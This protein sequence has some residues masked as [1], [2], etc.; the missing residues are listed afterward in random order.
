[1]LVRPIEA[2]DKDSLVRAF[3][4]L[5]PESRYRRFLASMKRLSP[6]LLRHLTEIDHRDHEALVALSPDELELVGV[7][8]FI[9][10]ANDPG[11]AE[12]AVAVVDHWQGRGV[13]TEL[14]R[15]LEDRALEEGVDR[16]TAICLAENREA[17]ELLEAVGPHR[18]TRTEDGI[19]EMEIQLPGSRTAEAPMRTA[20]QRA[21]SGALSFRHPLPRTSKRIIIGWDGSDR[22]RDAIDLAR[23]LGAAVGASLT[24]AAVAFDRLGALRRSGGQDELR[25]EAEQLLGAAPNDHMPGVTVTTRALVSTSP[26]RGLQNL[27]EEL[28]ADMIVLGSTHRGPLGR[29]FMGTVADDLLRGAPCAVSIAPRGYARRYANRLLQIVALAFDASPESQ[30]A[31]R[32]AAEIAEAAGAHVRV[33][34]V[35]E[36]TVLTG[37]S[38]ETLAEE[39]RNGTDLLVLGS[40]GSKLARISSCPVLVVPG[41]AG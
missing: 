41:R 18:I 9:R 14:L 12:V 20:L 31:A 26:G 24:V 13:A 30:A 35:V 36:G 7:A 27:A 2:D 5:N 39:T 1:V 8:R 37:D 19:V 22:A 33:I 15:R 4:T 11:A 16:F 17:L 10:L 25:R 38:A 40:R 6:G 3:E 21:A 23:V 29:V 34:A 28:A 32:T